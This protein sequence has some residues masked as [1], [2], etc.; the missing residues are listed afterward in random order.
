[1]TNTVY[2]IFKKENNDLQ[3]IAFVS[4]EIVNDFLESCR[5][6]NKKE[7]VFFFAQKIMIEN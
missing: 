3:E 6:D 1:M 2:R 7:N 4:S 5:K